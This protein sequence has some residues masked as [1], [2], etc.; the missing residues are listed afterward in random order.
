[1][2]HDCSAGPSLSWHVWPVFGSSKVTGIGF[3]KKEKKKKLDLCSGFLEISQTNTGSFL[4][5]NLV[6]EWLGHDLSLP[7]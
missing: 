7:D 1:M 5:G 6:M 2:G 4:Y 3:Q